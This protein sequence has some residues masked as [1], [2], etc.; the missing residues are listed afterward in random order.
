[1]DFAS[2]P[3]VAA[4]TSAG[5]LT[6]ASSQVKSLFGLKFQAEKFFDIWQNVFENISDLKLGDTILGLSCCTVLLLMRV[7][8]GNYII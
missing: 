8:F 2:T 7:C 4:F 6:I 1:M 3:V 5:A